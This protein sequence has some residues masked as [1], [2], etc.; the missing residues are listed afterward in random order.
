MEPQLQFSVPLRKPTLRKAHIDL[1]FESKKIASL[2]CHTEYL[3]LF[4]RKQQLRTQFQRREIDAKSYRAATTAAAKGFQAGYSEKL[5]AIRQALIAQGRDLLVRAHEHEEA[6]PSLQQQRRRSWE[7]EVDAHVTALVQRERQKQLAVLAVTSLL[8]KRLSSSS[9]GAVR[10][11]SFELFHRSRR[12]AIK[13]RRRRELERRTLR[14][15]TGP[16][17]ERCASSMQTTTRQ[18]LFGTIPAP[19]VVH[20]EMEYGGLSYSSWGHYLPAAPPTYARRGSG[21]GTTHA[22][23]KI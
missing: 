17:L 11:R 7:Q 23:S 15:G 20:R 9:S 16:V 3:N 2:I 6:R 8:H 22:G 19:T 4:L 18:A 12:A 5:E 10:R 13:Q 21:S 14:S 1:S